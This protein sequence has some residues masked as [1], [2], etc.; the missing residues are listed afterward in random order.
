MTVQDGKAMGKLIC[1][2]SFGRIGDKYRMSTNGNK[3]N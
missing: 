1:I 3:I 2:L